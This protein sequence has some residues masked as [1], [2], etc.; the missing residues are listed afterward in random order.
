M[1]STNHQPY[2]QTTWRKV[3]RA[4]AGDV[5][6]RAVELNSSSSTDLKRDT[7]KHLRHGS[8]PRYV[9]AS[10]HHQDAWSGLTSASTSFAEH[11]STHRNPHPSK[12]LSKSSASS[13]LS[14]RN[15]CP[16]PPASYSDS[17]RS[18]SDLSSEQDHAGI[19]LS[20]LA[21]RHRR[22]LAALVRQ[23]AVA[24]AQKDQLGLLIEASRQERTVLSDELKR[25]E[26]ER[27]SFEKRCTEIS[28]ELDSTQKLLR[29]YESQ[30]SGHSMEA[31]R[32]SDTKLSKLENQIADLSE[33]LQNF[34][35]SLSISL[36]VSPQP[37][38]HRPHSSP[39]LAAEVHGKRQPT[40]GASERSFR[41]RVNTLLSVSKKHALSIDE[42]SIYGPGVDMRTLL[43]DEH[44]RRVQRNPSPGKSLEHDRL[45][46]ASSDSV[47]RGR[48]NKPERARMVDSGT[49]AS[50]TEEKGIQVDN[51]QSFGGN[52]SSSPR[53]R[54][55]HQEGALEPAQ[56]ESN[57]LSDGYVAGTMRKARAHHPQTQTS[58]KSRVGKGTRHTRVS[59]DNQGHASQPHPQS[60]GGETHLQQTES[61]NIRQTPYAL[62]SHHWQPGQQIAYH[63]SP[64]HSQTIYAND[65]TSISAYTS[66]DATS[67]NAAIAAICPLCTGNEHHASM[68]HTIDQHQPVSVPIYLNVRRPDV[69]QQ[70]A[71][72]QHQK[73]P[74]QGNESSQ[75]L[76]QSIH[77]VGVSADT[78]EFLRSSLGPQP[79]TLFPQAEVHHPNQSTMNSFF[80]VDPH[81]ETTGVSPFRPPARTSS[82]FGQLRRSHAP[83]VSS[84]YQN[85]EMKTSEKRIRSQAE[86]SSSRSSSD[87][88]GSNSK[89]QARDRVTIP[90][91]ESAQQSATFSPNRCEPSRE[92]RKESPSQR[93]NSPGK[94]PV[95]IPG[96]S[97]IGSVGDASALSAMYNSSSMER[98][99]RDILIDLENDLPAATGSSAV[100][101][102]N[103]ASF[104]VERQGIIKKSNQQNQQH[105]FPKRAHVSTKPNPDLTQIIASLNNPRK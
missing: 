3:A 23:L 75:R 40:Q 7:S 101:Q 60:S 25:N 95:T 42:S 73:L 17:F 8:G 78:S 94:R 48:V 28:A 29:Q 49:Q 50:P 90:I 33:I 81:V 83:N 52:A 71:R 53:S 76:D 80:V 37:L 67:L 70:P 54:F 46:S 32:I 85:T 19:P 97:V 66:L 51:F 88:D 22:R 79:Q 45:S 26:R 20:E 6:R 56:S 43:V 93:D 98:S 72:Q 99:L 96:S 13:D 35:N 21:P 16:S 68:L 10:P 14:L 82:L 30:I 4:G 11:S 65:V 100:N 69:P 39:I 18:V 92:N 102:Q 12:Q 105:S 1:V 63:Q 86:S 47:S 5:P 34:A 41:S 55:K 36:S 64:N 104:P 91:H 58:Q 38:D 2:R 62:E 57:D 77:F 74:L 61:P 84:S 89:T 15:L 59:E 27:D 44:P 103:K 9:E 87:P 31:A 24:E